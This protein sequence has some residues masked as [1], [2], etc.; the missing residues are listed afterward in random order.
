MGYISTAQRTYEMAK[1]ITLYLSPIE[2]NALLIMLNESLEM[3]FY[4]GD[5]FDH[6]DWETFDLDAAR[7]TAYHKFRTAYEGHHPEEKSD[8]WTR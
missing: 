5:C 2:A 8:E 4:H 6:K 3:H 7:L 1:D